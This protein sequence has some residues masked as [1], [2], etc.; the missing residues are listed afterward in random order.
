MASADLQITTADGTGF[1]NR[2][3]G[4]F[5]SGYGGLTVARALQRRLPEESIV[6]FGDSARCPYGPRDQ[7]EV[8]RFVQQ[9][10]SWLTG[11]DVK[12]IVIA[13]NTATAA[14]LVHAQQVFDVPVV[15]VVEPGARAAAHTTRNRRVGVIATKGTVD[16]NAYADAIRHID[17][18]ITVFSTAT[19][20][21]VEIAEMGLRM[22]EGPIEDF[23]AEAT[24]VYIRPEFEDIAR[25]YLEPLR[26]C[27]IDTLVLGCTH[28]PLLKAL[29]GGVVG[30]PVTL[31]SSA[32]ETARD[33]DHIL[34]RRGA[35]AEPGHVPTASFFT[36]GVDTE[37]FRRFGGRVLSRPMD[38]VEHVD[39]PAV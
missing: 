12:M 36:T 15:G 3:I 19:P 23:M 16:S 37:E 34:T 30:R 8:D 20:R 33:V 11:R 26:R 17:A 6:Y 13:C 7:A 39:L 2:P 1:D 38:V 25:Q 4:V 31:V 32:D 9:I 22:S 35:H 14:G 18:G 27:E 29:I 28:Y 5:D 21:F 24:K 10:C